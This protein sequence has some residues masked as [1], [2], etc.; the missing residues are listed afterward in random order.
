M[1]P[2]PF[3]SAKEFKKFICLVFIFHMTI[4]GRASDNASMQITL[5]VPSLIVLIGISGSGKSTFARQHF[6]ATEI[7]SS[8]H[9][10]ALV[11]DDESDQSV[12]QDAFELLHLIAAK[13]LARRRLTVIDATNVQTEARAQLLAL[14]SAQQIP[15]VAIVFNFDVEICWQ[16][17]VGRTHRV[18]PHEILLQQHDDLQASLAG[19]PR[20]GFDAI[21]LLTSPV[22]LSVTTILRK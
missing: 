10:R 15:A 9:C 1:R 7:V 11:C 22:E 3:G 16:N 6:L 20:E 13:R 19:L 2:Q 17:N 18:V 8:D 12:N 14:A 21:H 5:A 4:I